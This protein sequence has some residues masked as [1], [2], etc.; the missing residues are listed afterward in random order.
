M[1][2]DTVNEN[3]VGLTGA[4][5][6]PKMP[7]MEELQAMQEEA[8]KAG[9]KHMLKMVTERR[10]V[11]TFDGKKLPEE[12]V[13]QIKDYTE[14]LAATNPF[15]IPVRFV[16][17]DADELGL[18]SPVIKGEHLYVAGIVEDVE[19]SEEA[20]GYAFEGLVLYAWALGV[21]TTWIGGTMKREVFEKAAGVQPGERMYCISPLGVA[22]QKMGIREVAMRKGVRADERK[23][24][25]EL[26]FNG[27]FTKPLDMAALA[28][29]PGG[30]VA[31]DALEA[32]RLAPSA[33]NKQPWRIVRTGNTWHFYEKHGRGQGN[34][35]W[36]IQRVDIGIALCHFVMMTGGRVVTEDPGIATFDDTDYICSVVLQQI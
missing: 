21:G 3:Q 9:R 12:V 5:G 2:A 16:F 30:D 11:R 24:A 10:S 33:V 20:Y 28:A 35:P 8:M 4:E 34:A 36:D 32:V 6:A 27:D 19:H 7:S 13:T 18:S 1:N 22:A 31:A 14:I 26:F 17:L 15:K 29:E 23:S 25:G